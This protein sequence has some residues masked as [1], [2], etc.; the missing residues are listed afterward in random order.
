MGYLCYDGVPLSL[1]YVEIK[2]AHFPEFSKIRR[3]GVRLHHTL[4]PRKESFKR[5]PESFYNLV[6]CFAGDE[7]AAQF[8]INNGASVNSLTREEG[9][10]PLHMLAA[11][12]YDNDSKY[13]MEVIPCDCFAIFVHG[14]LILC[15]V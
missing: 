9:V 6:A 14:F 12:T 11:A 3:C 8:L 15:F 2:T 5:I 7:F 4:T 13:D 10:S 1:S